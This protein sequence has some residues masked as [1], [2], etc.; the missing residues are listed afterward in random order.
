[1]EH[2]P[3]CP[4]SWPP[5]IHSPG[6]SPLAVPISLPTLPSSLLERGVDP[7]NRSLEGWR[8]V[9]VGCSSACLQLEPCTS[10]F[11]WE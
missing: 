3:G 1:M 4:A 9:L 8:A 2:V 6:L 5:L 11:Q 7:I 10:L